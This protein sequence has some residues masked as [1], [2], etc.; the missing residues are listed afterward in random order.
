[1]KKIISLA[2]LVVAFT[3]ASCN[4][5]KETQTVDSTAVEN[6][7]VAPAPAPAEEKTVTTEETTP[8]TPAEEAP[9]TDAA[10]ETPAN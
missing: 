9:A 8:A 5:A 7:E 2:A 10:A 3:F 1:M 6:T 4:G